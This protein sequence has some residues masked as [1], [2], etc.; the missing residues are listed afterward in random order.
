MSFYSG[1]KKLLAGL[2]RFIFNVK[3]IGAE[4]EPPVGSYLI[5]A[6]HIS[7]AD[8]VII[9]ASI[10]HNP[11]YMAKKELMSVPILKQL[12]TALGAY[13][14][15][16]KGNDVGAIKKT[17]EMLKN[18]E[19]IIMFPQG[20]R[21]RGVN[22]SET[23]IKH[24][25]ALIALRSETP[26]LPIYI[27]T[28]NYKIRLFKRTE[29]IIGKPIPFSDIKDAIGENNDFKAGADLVFSKILELNSGSN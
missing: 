13:P 2:I 19:S 21:Y 23:S 16:R 7:E 27:K 20:T 4:N 10:M 15:D 9:G 1:A 8:P 22:P 18:G 6:N 25:C 28:K 26:I 12:V 11:K 17:I 14:I 24:G 5:C 29:I 3:I